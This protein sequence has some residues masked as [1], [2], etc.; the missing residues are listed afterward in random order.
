MQ[1]VVDGVSL[2]IAPGQTLGVVGESGSGKTVTALSVP[3]LLT[4]PGQIMAGTVR[5]RGSL[6]T[7]MTERRLRRVR[8]RG[9][10][11]VAQEPM[12]ALDPSFT[13][14]SQLAEA[15]RHFGTAR[16][17]APARAR[18]LLADVGISDPDRVARC[19]PH[20]LSGGMAQRVAIALALTGDPALII[21]D[22]P[23]TALDVTV[24]AAILDLF[25]EL[26]GDGRRSL[27]LV[28]HDLGVVADICDTAGQIVEQGRT[29]AVL[30]A[31]R[32][33]YTA[34]LLASMPAV[35]GA[36]RLRTIDGTVPAPGTWPPGCRFADRCHLVRDECRASP[37][38]LLI[39]GLDDTPDNAADSG[40]QLTRCLRSDALA[41]ESAI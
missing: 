35:D 2:R 33:P 28:T 32:N 27:L 23:T 8:G 24:Q 13:I 11:Y 9:I 20:Q 25:R 41:Q 22:E 4:A 40:G 3:G 19:F 37:I 15:L 7:Q 10:A 16:R 30:R 17:A 21:A 26:V 38:P 6:V 34:A 29:A 31:P 12:A 1:P 36:D 14:G 5:F 18:Q 39:P